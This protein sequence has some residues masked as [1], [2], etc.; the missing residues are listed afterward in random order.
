MQVAI[1]I[2]SILNFM[3]IILLF[4]ANANTNEL[5]KGQTGKVAQMIADTLKKGIFGVKNN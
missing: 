5:I 3:L 1:L 4:G 2:F